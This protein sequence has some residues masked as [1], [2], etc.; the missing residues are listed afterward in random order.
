MCPVKIPKNLFL[1][2]KLSLLEGKECPE[3]FPNQDIFISLY[4]LLTL[5]SYIFLASHPL[6]VDFHLSALPTCSS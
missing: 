3:N 5:S 1:K 6:R 4:E 2:I